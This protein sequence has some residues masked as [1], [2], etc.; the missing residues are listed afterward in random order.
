MD[1]FSMACNLP[2][3]QPHLKVA[4]LKYLHVDCKLTRG[5]CQTLNGK[6]IKHIMDKPQGR[7]ASAIAEEILRFFQGVSP[8][9]SLCVRFRMTQKYSIANGQ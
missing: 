1:A 6:A 5:F 8:L 4:S 7:A 9:S 2:L 3:E